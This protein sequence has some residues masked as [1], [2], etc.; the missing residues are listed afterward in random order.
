MKSLNLP[1]NSAVE[2]SS[3][4]LIKSNDFNF[5]VENKFNNVEKSISE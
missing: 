3:D 1:E 2:S 4:S 5:Y